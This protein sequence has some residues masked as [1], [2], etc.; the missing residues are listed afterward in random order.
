MKRYL[1]L[2]HRW[3]GIGLC[4]VMV[5]WFVS[6]VVMLYVGYPKLTPAERLQHLPAL[7]TGCCLP[8]DVTQYAE[9]LTSLRLVGIASQPYYLL[10]TRDGGQ[11]VVDARTGEPAPAVDAE[12]ALASA[13]QFGGGAP[14]RYLG[15]V[16]E[17]IWTHSRALDA[18]RPLHLVELQDPARTWLY[19][20]SRSGEVVR[21]ASLEERRWNLLGAWLH[22]LYPLRGGFGVENGW[23]LLV[24]GLSLL[25][26]AMAVLG[27]W[28]GVLRWRFSGRYRSG[29]RS[30]YGSGWMR[31][32]HIGGLLFGVLLVLWVFSGLMSMRPWGLF[33]ARSTLNLAAYQGGDLRVGDFPLAVDQAL[34]VLR[35]DAGFQPVELEWRTVG[36]QAYL[37]ARSASGDSRVLAASDPTRVLHTL[38]REVL[39]AAAQATAPGLA[40][41]SEWLERFDF[42]YFA[43]AEQSMYGFQHRRLPVLRVRFDDPQASWLHIDPYSGAIVD[44][45]DQHRRAGRWLFNLLH[46][47]DWQPLLERPR[48][49]EALIIAFSLGGLLICL[50]GTVLGWRRLRRE[51][52]GR[53]RRLEQRARQSVS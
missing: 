48:L 21:D 13:G 42:Y 14:A 47:W 1:Y 35:G 49:R 30:P 16:E 18:D 23:R 29:S 38:P 51:A 3:L 37:L 50:S 53:S 32:H 5:L 8:L 52:R 25:G 34:A 15:R 43:R 19:V 4:L 20:S 10:T 45:S 7:P 44:L 39:L 24:I 17:D 6:G 33:D 11:Q 27:I 31:W 26:T 41:R 22:W 40:M 36:G 28:V 46:S 12:R 9:P 2:W